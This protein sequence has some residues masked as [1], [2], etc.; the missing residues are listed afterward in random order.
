M[1]TS[2]DGEFCIDT[3]ASFGGAA[4]CGVF[5]MCADAAC[6]ILR[7]KGIGPVVKWVDDH[8]F[9]R[10]RSDLIPAYNVKRQNW[11]RLIQDCGGQHHTGGRLWFGGDELAD[12][13]IEEFAEDMSCPLKVLS[14]GEFPYSL[15]DV[16]AVTDPLGI[17][18]EL[19]K[20]QDFA[21]SV[22]FTGLVWDLCAYTVDLTA[23][24]REK[25]I[26]TIVDWKKKPLH[27]L[28][29]TQKLLGKLLHATQVVPGGRAYLTCLEAFL[30]VFGDTP[31]MPRRPP[32]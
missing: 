1:R 21:S 28:D 27:T 23:K 18:W 2:N 30:G 9:V 20:D 16:N 13:R 24:K 5:G 12:G 29:E 32:R 19:Q 22:T 3:C 7:A 15:A 11:H 6:D 17:V 31:L 14:S 8:A 4:N 10:I 26:Q 25:Y